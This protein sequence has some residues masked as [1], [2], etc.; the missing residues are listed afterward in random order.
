MFKSKVRWDRVPA[1]NPLA[2][3]SDRRARKFA[4]KTEAV[5]DAAMEIVMHSG[6]AGLTLAKVARSLDV[7]IGGLYRY[8]PSK[9]ALV[10]G[11][12]QR[13]VTRFGQRLDAYLDALLPRLEQTPA[14]TR[15]A[16][17]AVAPFWFYVEQ[18]RVQPDDHRLMD[19]LLSELR[20]TLSDDQA[21]EVESVLGPILMRAQLGL[22]AAADAS[23]IDHGDARART[24]IL[25]GATHG[26]GHLR[27]RERLEAPPYH[28]DPLCRA[29]FETLLRGFGASDSLAAAAVAGIVNPP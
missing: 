11:L 13:A 26:I 22:E 25:W 4:A 5:L 15:A 28:V 16:G 19:V 27:S 3:R 21:R 10:T 18:A 23:A 7:A 14:P 17:F 1:S 2:P 9:E 20:P 24:L 6:L 12:Q 8:F 29:L